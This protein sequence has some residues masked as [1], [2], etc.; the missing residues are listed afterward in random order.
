MAR[1]VFASILLSLVGTLATNEA[2]IKFLAA[3]KEKEG[4][5]TLASGLQYKVIRAGDGDSH[6][7]VESPCECHCACWLTSARTP[8]TTR[9]KKHTH[10]HTQRSLYVLLLTARGGDDGDSRAR[11]RGPHCGQLPRGPQV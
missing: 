9:Q 2:G 8:H 7:T 4:V 3:N 1:M 6:P 10:T 5:V 11:R